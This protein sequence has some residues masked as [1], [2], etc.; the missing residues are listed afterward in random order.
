[1]AFSTGHH[2]CCAVLRSTVLCITAVYYCLVCASEYR[3]SCMHCVLMRSRCG[4]CCAVQVVKWGRNVFA[5]LQK[6]IQFQ[7]TV[8]IGALLIDFI[9]ACSSGKHVPL[10]AVQVSALPATRVGTVQG[11]SGTVPGWSGT[12]PGSPTGVPLASLG[13]PCS[14]K[15]T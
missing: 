15:A 9:V 4:V 8:N 1:M 6:F 3:A 7:I 13:S 12:V 5:N 14:H 10:T 2:V 11:W